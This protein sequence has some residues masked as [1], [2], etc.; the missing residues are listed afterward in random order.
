MH[1]EDVVSSVYFRSLL[2]S[3]MYSAVVPVTATD[4]VFQLQQRLKM[5]KQPGHVIQYG[6]YTPSRNWHVTL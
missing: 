5:F 3:V 2:R 1:L 4:K 6:R